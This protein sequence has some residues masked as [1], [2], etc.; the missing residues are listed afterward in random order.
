MGLLQFILIS[1]FSVC[2][3]A[4]SE[5]PQIESQPPLVIT[6]EDQAQVSLYHY[7]GKNRRQ[8]PIILFP[9]IG[10]NHLVFDLPSSGGLAPYLSRKGRDV[11]VVEFRGPGSGPRDWSLDELLGYDLPQA[12]DRVG[13]ETKRKDFDLI[14]LGISGTILL[15]H[16]SSEPNPDPGVDKIILI[17]TPSSTQAAN[18]AVRSWAGKAPG[19]AEGDKSELIDLK[20]T[21]QAPAPWPAVPGTLFHL[22]FWGPIADEKTE[23]EICQTV[24]ESIPPGTAQQLARWVE[25]GILSSRDG[26]RN[27]L[28]NLKNIRAPVLF[29]SGQLDNLAPPWEAEF[30]YRAISSEKKKIRIFGRANHYRK[31]YGHFDLILGPAAFHEVY[32][33]L[34][35]WLGKN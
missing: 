2:G 26:K 13:I 24:F 23:A 30:A 27:Y 15:E 31:E 5:L 21:C 34:L 28:I 17:N 14:G 35:D 11:W 25:T 33:Y 9:E 18:L 3:F 29:L 6:T 8:P 19:L 12:L 32:P 1:Y 20:K 16:L 22:L 7:P 10:A 4:Y